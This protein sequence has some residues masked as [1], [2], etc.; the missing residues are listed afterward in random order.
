MGEGFLKAKIKG[1]SDILIQSAGLDTAGMI[2]KYGGRPH[3]QV[4]EVMREIGID[5]SQQEITQAT[6]KLLADSTQIL[7]LTDQGELPDSFNHFRDKMA[8][9]SIEDP[10]PGATNDV[11]IQRLRVIRDQIERVMREVVK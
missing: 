6:L 5:I 7:V 9:H 11:D 2:D 4:I 8:F 10:A 3:P 1:D